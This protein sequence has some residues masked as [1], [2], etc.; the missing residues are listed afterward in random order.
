MEAAIIGLTGILVCAIGAYIYLH[1]TEFKEH[2]P[3]H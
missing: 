2:T 1:F 3:A